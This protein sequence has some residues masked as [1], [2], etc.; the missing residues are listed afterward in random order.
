VET[1][2][3]DTNSRLTRNSRRIENLEVSSRKYNVLIGG[4]ASDRRLER[5]AHL[6]KGVADFFKNVLKL[7]D[8]PFDEAER[9]NEPPA[10]GA[11]PRNFNFVLFLEILSGTDVMIF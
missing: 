7:D 10:A 8:V 2:I 11:L 3:Q 9:V 1:G 6:E 4:L 5:H